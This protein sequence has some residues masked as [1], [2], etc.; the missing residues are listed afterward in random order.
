[1]DQSFAHMTTGIILHLANIALLYGSRVVVT[2]QIFT[3]Y[4]NT[5]IK[6]YSFSLLI[7]IDDIYVTLKTGI[8]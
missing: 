8:A 7:D 3:K 5:M 1:M 4:E 6:D 2:Y